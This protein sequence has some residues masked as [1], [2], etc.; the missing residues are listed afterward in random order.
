M[1][2]P[3]YLMVLKKGPEAWNLFR[4]RNLNLNVNLKK[5]NLNGA[6]LVG[7]NLSFTNLSEAKLVDANL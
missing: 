6:K 7:A 5:A 4:Q 2:N 1:A 3:I